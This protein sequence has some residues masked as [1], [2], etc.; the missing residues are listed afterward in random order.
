MV[1]TLCQS[2]AT[3]A[4]GATSAHPHSGGSIGIQLLDAPVSRRDDPRAREY[5]ID[6]LAPGTTIRRRVL[7]SNTTGKTQSIQVYGAAASIQDGRFIFGNGH[8]RNDVTTWTS[9]NHSDL[10]LRRRSRAPVWVTIKVPR[11]AAPGERYAV[12]WAQVTARPTRI[13]NIGAINRV[14]IRVYLD[15]SPGGEPASNFRIESMTAGRTPHGRPMVTARVRNTGGRA[16]DL[17]GSLTLSDDPGTL[18]AGPFPISRITTLAPGDVAPVTIFLDNKLPKGPWHA[19]LTL[20]SGL[21][22]RTSEAVITFPP[23]GFGV[24]IAAQSI[25]TRSGLFS[26]LFAILLLCLGC[27]GAL[28]AAGILVWRSRRHAGTD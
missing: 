2:V 22:S 18:N 4:F 25:A 19:Q 14:G 11:S 28:V 13:G 12:V 3:T 1:A 21:L 24:S 23:S 8:A 17:S 7:V 9:V 26:G 16:V 20:V 6:H 5:I 27:G 15:V 10:H